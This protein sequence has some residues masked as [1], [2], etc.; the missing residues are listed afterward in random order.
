[1]CVY[2]LRGGRGGGGC[3]CRHLGKRVGWVRDQPPYFT[4]PTSILTYVS[5][6]SCK[7]SC[8]RIVALLQ[9]IFTA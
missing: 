2:L 5:K 7:S 9:Q 4:L 3:R 6:Y 1:M 8:T